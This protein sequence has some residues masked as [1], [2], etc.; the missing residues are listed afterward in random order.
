[1]LHL[2]PQQYETL[3]NLVEG[4]DKP[5]DGRSVRALQKRGLVNEHG[6]ATTQGWHTVGKFRFRPEF[7]LP[8]L[9]DIETYHQTAIGVVEAPRPDFRGSEADGWHRADTYTYMFDAERILLWYRKVKQLEQ[10]HID[11]RWD[12]YADSNYEYEGDK[13]LRYLLKREARDFALREDQDGYYTNHIFYDIA[14]QLATHSLNMTSRNITTSTSYKYSLQD[15]TDELTRFLVA[16]PDNY[17][18]E[19]MWTV[20]VD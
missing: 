15:N 5:V 7:E 2:N 10:Q 1:M 11:H 19:F 4:N 17:T 12:G 6:H 8:R 18:M 16:D 13:G 9:I 3:Y 14:T 20:D